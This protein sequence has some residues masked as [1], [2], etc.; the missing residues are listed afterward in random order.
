MGPFCRQ[1]VLSM[2]K[3]ILMKNSQGAKVNEYSYQQEQVKKD[4]GTLYLFHQ[5]FFPFVL[6]C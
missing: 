2:H 6:Y 3:N 5:L 4:I 1:I